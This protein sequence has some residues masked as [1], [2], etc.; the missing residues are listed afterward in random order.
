VPFAERAQEQAQAQRQ[1]RAQTQ[2]QAHAQAHAEETLHTNSSPSADNGL[3]DVSLSLAT[4]ERVVLLGPSGEGKTTL[5]RA[6]AGL[7]A[8]SRGTV[9]VNGRDV[10]ALAPEQ[11][12]AVYLHQV[13]VLFPHLSVL[14]NVSFPMTVRGVARS[15]RLRV[16]QS[17][18]ERLHLGA[19]GN[20]LPHMLSGGQRHR[21]ALA[22]ALAAQP[23]VLLLDEPLSALDPALRRDVR[24]A[25][26]EA[27][28]DSSAGLLLV[29][30][31]LDDATTLGDRIA[32]MLD[33]T[34][35]QI[36]PASEL[37]ARPASLAVMRF[38]GVHQELQGTMQH[39]HSVGTALGELVLPS[40]VAAQLAGATRVTVGIRTD[41]LRCEPVSTLQGG[42]QQ[43]SSPWQL[44]P[45]QSQSPAPQSQ[46]PASQSKSPPSQSQSPASQSQSPASQSQSPASQLQSPPSPLQLP[47]RVEQVHARSSGSTASVRVGDIVVQALINPLSAPAVHD[48]VTLTIDARGIIAFRA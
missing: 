14:D 24:D 23:H 30:H 44:S 11:R 41:A 45:S 7:S 18:L 2:A 28:N 3:R 34:L 8:V 38:L 5:L 42:Y 25:I 15:E 29:T 40:D 19:L 4:G 22:R 12:D 37:F 31:D 33:R 10:T 39:K 6:I 13:P 21:V 36:A 20:R 17:L 16:A 9:R 26:R 32:I 43:P 1:P 27:H 35:V 48:T 47:A 46:S